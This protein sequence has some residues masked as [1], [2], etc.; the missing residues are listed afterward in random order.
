MW[1]GVVC[2]KIIF[3]TKIYRIKHSAHEIFVIYGISDVACFW[4]RNS[5]N[6]NGPGDE[7]EPNTA[8]THRKHNIIHV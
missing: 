6:G 5:E 7:A 2:L 8:T 3:Y 4:N 1:Y